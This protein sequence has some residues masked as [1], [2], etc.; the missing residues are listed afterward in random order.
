MGREVIEVF[1][2]RDEAQRLLIDMLRGPY[3]ANQPRCE[4]GVLYL[5]LDAT[6]EGGMER[7]NVWV[8]TMWVEPRK[9]EKSGGCAA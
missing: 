6:R 3:H 4:R 2:D 1:T 5:P 9:I 8:V 7:R